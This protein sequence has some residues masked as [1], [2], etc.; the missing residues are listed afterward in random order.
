MER[1]PGESLYNCFGKLA[2]KDIL[3]LA[4]EVADYL[5]QLRTFTSDK[6]QAPGGMLIRNKIFSPQHPPHFWTSDVDE[7]WAQVEPH[8]EDKSLKEILKEKYPLCIKP[9]GPF[10]LTHGDLNTQNIMVK[11]KHISGIIDWER[12]GY[13]PEWWEWRQLLKVHDSS[14]GNIV[15][16]ALE[17][18]NAL[19]SE[20]VTNLW[21]SFYTI[22]YNTYKDESGFKVHNPKWRT[23][24][25][26]F[27]WSQP[28]YPHYR[29]EG[30]SF[31]CENIAKRNRTGL[32]KI[33]AEKKAIEDRIKTAEDRAKVA[34]G[35]LAE[36]ETIL[37]EFN[38]L[39]VEE[40]E[41]LKRRK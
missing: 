20:E 14:W 28:S 15:L 30:Q 9:G 33:E 17:R 40:R 36:N 32:E 19:P 24:D 29:A 38:K 35:K 3:V 13:L 10:V 2:W 39:S 22:F 34:E 37:T 18:R 27:Y 8:I 16:K 26:E 41:N 23:N 31:A 1:V 4:E 12:G 21:S 25:R 7:W 6:L 11:D 5:V